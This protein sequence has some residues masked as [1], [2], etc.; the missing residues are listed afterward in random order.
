MGGGGGKEEGL[1]GVIVGVEGVKGR[2]KEDVAAQAE[3]LEFAFF[4]SHWA[5]LAEGSVLPA[6]GGAAR[7]EVLA[8]LAGCALCR[9]CG[10]RARHRGVQEGAVCAG[11]GLLLA[12][13]LGVAVVLAVEALR[14][15][16]LVPVWIA[17][18]G[19]DGESLCNALVCGEGVGKRNKEQ[20]SKFLGVTQGLGV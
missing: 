19:F 8:A 4:G 18:G 20:G 15:Q 6:A 5:V 3:V 11:R 9:A 13:V 16:F 10:A 17:D 14:G 7:C 1:V 12:L 2:V